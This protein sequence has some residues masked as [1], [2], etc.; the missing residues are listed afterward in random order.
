MSADVDSMRF[1]E[2]EK[3]L[4]KNFTSKCRAVV[5]ISADGTTPEAQ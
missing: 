4:K 3:K 2:H 1:Y 5:L